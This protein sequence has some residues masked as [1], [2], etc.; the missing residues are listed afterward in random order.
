MIRDC[1]DHK[2]L[3]GSE[4]TWIISSQRRT[5]TYVVEQE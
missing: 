4:R 5:L 3:P 2:S 1:R